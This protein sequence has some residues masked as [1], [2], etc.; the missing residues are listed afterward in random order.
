MQ[1]LAQV[2]AQQIDQPLSLSLYI[3][4]TV[5][6]DVMWW[7]IHDFNIFR[8][9]G[10][11]GVSSRLSW[12]W[13]WWHGPCHRCEP[14]DSLLRLSAS[15]PVVEAAAKA[16]WMRRDLLWKSAALHVILAHCHFSMSQGIGLSTCFSPAFAQRIL[17]E[18]YQPQS[19]QEKTHTCHQLM[20]LYILS[21]QLDRRPTI[22]LLQSL[23]SP[24]HLIA[25]ESQVLQTRKKPMIWRYVDTLESWSKTWEIVMSSC[26]S[27]KVTKGFFVLDFVTACR[28]L[29]KSNQQST[30]VMI[31]K[32]AHHFLILLLYAFVW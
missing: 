27:L 20:S 8:W 21:E 4:I 10:V 24:Y 3:H 1:D 18:E 25:V 9:F 5:Q 16:E 23:F 7:G 13:R 15:M 19:A 22:F 14:S 28:S 31:W 29:S 11:S 6:C 2:P 32:I 17:L 30:S 26:R 12:I